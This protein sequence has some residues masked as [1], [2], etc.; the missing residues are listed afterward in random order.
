VAS[1]R[2]NYKLPVART[3]E[4]QRKFKMDIIGFHGK[5]NK[6]NGEQK[7]SKIL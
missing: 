6:I 4:R 3:M 2:K 5:E 1:D 7:Y